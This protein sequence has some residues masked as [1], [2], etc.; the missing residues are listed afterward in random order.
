RRFEG[1]LTRRFSAV[2][3]TSQTD[4]QALIDLGGAPNQIHVI[5]NGVDLEYFRPMDT[6]RDPLRLVFSGKMS[7]HANVAAVQDLVQK[8]M[9]LVWAQ[10]PDVHLQIV[11]KDPTPVIQMLGEQPNITVTGFVPDLRPYL[12]EAAVAVST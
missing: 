7:Y 10:Q 5:P 1:R 3:V 11:G 6:P 12:A 9:P 2:A 8:I 4:R